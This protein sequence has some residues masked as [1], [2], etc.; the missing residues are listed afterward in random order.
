MFGVEE[1]AAV[2][3]LGIEYAVFI[4]A[5]AI[6][7]SEIVF[8]KMFRAMRTLNF[9]GMLPRI[10]FPRIHLHRFLATRTMP[11][12][13]NHPR[14]RYGCAEYRIPE[15]LSARFDPGFGIGD[16]AALQFPAPGRFLSVGADIA[17]PF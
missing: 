12:G 4:E 13:P 7:L 16:N 14:T 9:P 1:Q 5:G 8:R 15:I 3:L 11:I 17:Q 6:K 10:T 2:G